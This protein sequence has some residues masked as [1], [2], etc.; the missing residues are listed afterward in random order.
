MVLAG[1]VGSGHVE[2]AM[3]SS[4][5]L[6]ATRRGLARA[7]VAEGVVLPKQTWWITFT[8]SLPD[9][10]NEVRMSFT[11]DL[12]AL[13]EREIKFKDFSEEYFRTSPVPP[14]WVS[15]RFVVEG[16]RAGVEA[17]AEALTEVGR[18][19]GRP[20]LRPKTLLEQ[21]ADFLTEHAPDSIVVLHT[22]TDLARLYSD[23][24]TRWHEFTLFLRGLQRA[25]KRWSGI[26]VADLTSALLEK[27]QE[28]EIVECA[29]GVLGF[30]W[31]AA[32]AMGRRR[33]MYFRKFRGL[34]PRLDSA[35]TMKF[36]VSTTPTAGLEVT[37]AEMIEGIR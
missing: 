10:L 13:F 4:I 11:P 16:R 7:P 20:A 35:A 25:A 14:E 24:E 27:Q 6:A 18:V 8:R 22:L 26:I 21:L 12:Y 5:M 2:F 19:A 1:E 3:T 30:A 31:E 32:G 9:L 15:D 37:R 17:L 29:D 34:L 28:E 36:E 33:V 23:T